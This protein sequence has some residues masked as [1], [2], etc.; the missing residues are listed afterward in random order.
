MTCLSILQITDLHIQPNLDDHFLGINTED[1]F[2]RVLDLAFSKEPS[3][4]L[5]LLTGDLAQAPCPA[6][7]QRILERINT[8]HTPCICLPGNHDDFALMQEVFNIPKINCQKQTV[9]KNWQVICLNSQI[10]GAPGGRLLPEELQFL[11]DCLKSNPDHH[12]LIAVHHHCIA[13]KSTWLD[14]MQIENSAELLTILE[15]YSQVKAI[16][17]GHIHQEKDDLNK[18]IHVFGTPSTC[19]QFTP[20]SHHFSLD[21]TMPGYRVIK[22]YENG[23]IESE[24]TRLPGTLTELQI[25]SSGY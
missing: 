2:H 9:F 12:A 15:S 7:Y 25:E 14:T 24:V 10:I 5:I 19:F 1:Y 3:I 16:T 20:N 22:L 18:T 11:E 17:T 8:T 6:S 4:D 23:E 13:T 21:N